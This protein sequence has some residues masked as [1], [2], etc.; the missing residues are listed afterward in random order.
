M[1]LLLVALVLLLTASMSYAGSPAD[2][3][4][5]ANTNAPDAPSPEPPKTPVALFFAV[6]EA[7][8]KA[9]GERFA[10]LVDTTAFRI[11]LK[12]GEAPTSAVTRTAAAFLFQDQVRLTA[13]KAFSIVRFHPTKKGVMATAA[14]SAEWGGSRGQ[15][16]VEVTLTAV[17]RGGRW[18]LSEVRAKD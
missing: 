18:L 5:N 2:G 8:I 11:A 14:W 9:D 16:D 17:L 10:S 1:R 15:R 12:P 13:T 4:A 6:E 3:N 7:W